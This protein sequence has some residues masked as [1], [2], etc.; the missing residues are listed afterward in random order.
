MHC[1]LP[2]S[3]QNR[4]LESLK[5]RIKGVNIVV[6]CRSDRVEKNDDGFAIHINHNRMI[7][8]NSLL[9]TTG[10]DIFDAE[11]KEEYGYGIYDNVITSVEL[12]KAF[13]SGVAID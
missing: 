7:T 4:L 5:Q 6:Q 10:F 11:R 3:R 2:G 13:K 1:F 12:E 9:L 8:A